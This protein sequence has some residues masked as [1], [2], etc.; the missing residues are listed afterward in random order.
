MLH[1][2][3]IR[4]SSAQ[5]NPRKYA[6]KSKKDFMYK[7]ATKTDKK[8][9]DVSEGTAL[10]KQGLRKV[11]KEKNPQETFGRMGWRSAYLQQKKNVSK[12]SPNRWVYVT[13]RM[14]EESAH[15]R[16]PYRLLPFKYELPGLCRKEDSNTA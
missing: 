6:L 15:T 2:E 10:C 12:H 11:E 1:G 14:A 3:I 8:V 5:K 7:H 13:Q 4:N 9:C 16:I